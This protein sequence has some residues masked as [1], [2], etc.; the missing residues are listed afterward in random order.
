[1]EKNEV[2]QEYREGYIRGL[3]SRLNEVLNG[4]KIKAID[5]NII[6]SISILFFETESVVQPQI[7]KFIQRV[8]YTKYEF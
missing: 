4:D 8:L 3:F 1:L 6:N 5:H 2:T 7:E